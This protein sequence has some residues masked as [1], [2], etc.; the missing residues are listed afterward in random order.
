MDGAGQ[1]DQV[2]HLFYSEQSGKSGKRMH[3]LAEW[4]SQLSALITQ[5]GENNSA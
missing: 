2:G 4:T 5:I 1:I 3:V